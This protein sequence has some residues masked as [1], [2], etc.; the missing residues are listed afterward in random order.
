MDNSTTLIKFISSKIL[1]FESKIHEL[2]KY[3]YVN[4]VN[5]ILSLGRYIDCMKNFGEIT[6]LLKVISN[7]NNFTS[8][9]L[10]ELN[11]INRLLSIIIRMNGI[12]KLEDLLNICIE[13]NY[14]NKITDKKIL[15]KLDLINIYFHPLN[16]NI[17]NWESDS[18]DEDLKKINF[19][20]KDTLSGLN[21]F[22]FLN[23]EK[24]T[25]DKNKVEYNF[26][27][28]MYCCFLVIQNESKKQTY[29]IKGFWDNVNLKYFI[30]N[31]YIDAKIKDFLEE[32]NDSEYKNQ[33]L[34]TLELKDLFILNT[35]QIKAKYFDTI[36][37]IK[38]QSVRNIQNIIKDFLKLDLFQKRQFLINLLVINIFTEQQYLAYLLYD[39]ITKDANGNIDSFEQTLIYDSFPFN[40]KIKF[41]DS[42]EKTMQ[43]TEELNSSVAA[44]KV[45]YENQI[46]LMKCSDQVKEKAI[47]KLKEI[48]GKNDDSFLKAKNYLEGL[49]RIPF[50]IV[51]I[52]PI[53]KV[54]EELKKE[55]ILYKESNNLPDVTSDNLVDLMVYCK[56]NLINIEI[57][58]IIKIS[59]EKLSKKQI[60]SIY[61]KCIDLSNNKKEIKPTT[62]KNSV[63]KY[64]NNLV[65]KN[66]ELALNN[67]L[68]SEN[69]DILTLKFLKINNILQSIPKQINIIRSNLDSCVYGHDEAKKQVERIIG[70]WISGDS[71]GYCFGFEGPPG[72]GKTT[73]A[74]K[75]IANCLMDENL[76]PRPFSMIQLGGDSNGSSLHGHNYTYV[77]SNWGNIVQILMDSKCMNPI[78]FIDEVDKVSKTENGRE[79][80]GILTHLLDVSQN[81]SFQDKY[82][83]GI[84]IDL[85][86]VL[87]ILSYNDVELID[88][89]LLDR[90]HR[91]KFNHLTLEEKIVVSKQ[92]ILP[93][94]LSKMGLDEK[95]NFSDEVLRFVIEKYTNESGVRKLKE[96]LFNI[97]GDINLNI[98]NKG[99][100]EIDHFPHQVTEEQITNFF[101]KDR[102]QIKHKLIHKQNTIGIINGLWANA[103]GHGGIIP[104]QTSYFPTTQ[105]LQLKLT[106]MQGDVMKESMNVA[107]T[108]AWE[109][110]PKKKQED[111]LK[112]F[113]NNNKGIHIHCPEGA[114]PKDG[115]SAGAAIT[116]A[117]YSLLNKI[118][119]KNEFG[120]TGEISLDGN[121][122][123]IGGLDLK[124][125][126]GIR[127]GIKQFIYPTENDEDFIKI[128]EKMKEKIENIKF[129]AV[130]HIDEVFNII[131]EYE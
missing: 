100:S 16:L 8:S 81:D 7:T 57:S 53:L 79:I 115:P 22:S 77:G 17:I 131:L 95:I 20:T 102:N 39:L 33:F 21:N 94:L 73:L 18:I 58:D 108:I 90:I 74:K 117:I 129:F 11:E 116:T 9:T 50:G 119:I 122:T 88:R 98:L 112:S 49:L 27:N 89:I 43:Y 42:M 54:A 62:N 67:S 97:I 48:K 113:K 32:S 66:P 28:E 126:G 127:A 44:P 83:S 121:V 123:A 51:R 111:L 130:S 85:S 13:Y 80:I 30:N 61:N 4:K 23:V 56:S 99:I 76:I 1:F 34:D 70:Q 124:I 6:N 12:S 96:L 14:L 103:Y 55:L 72:V 64:I 118:K 78:I 125:M 59:L 35:L 107:L 128:K 36:Q 87:F 29:I 69:L 92:H 104:I 109:K 63:I 19:N 93:E 46:A 5:S 24:E 10:E 47:Q 15:N 3:Y 86:K 110:T 114:V 75:G 120:I 40:I 101:L 65:N 84:N 106:G 45:S 25:N 52:E 41:Q 82:F 71:S 68:L 31:N 38:T 91:I 26:F 105:N 37:Q 60:V 2:S